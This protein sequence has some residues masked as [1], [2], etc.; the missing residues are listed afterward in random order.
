MIIN[1]Q[2]PDAIQQAVE[3]L[4]RGDVVVIPT[5]TVYGLAADASQPQAVEKIFHYKKRP[6]SNPLI[7]HIADV[8]QLSD[9]AIH[10]PLV[11]YQLAER[12]WPG[13]L[14][15]IVNKAPHVSDAITAGQATV[16]LRIPAHPVALQVLR[17]F[18]GG[19]AA[20][21]ANLF[22]EVSPTLATHVALAE[23]VLVLDG[24]P[25]QVGIESTIVDCSGARLAILRPG[26]LSALMISEVVGYDVSYQQA[27]EIKRPG[28]HWLHYSPKAEVVL[29][30]YAALT[31]LPAMPDTGFIVY[32]SKVAAPCVCLSVDPDAYAR[33]L[34]A[35]LHT[36]DKTC[37]RIVVE[38]PPSTPAWYAVHER[39]RKAAGM[40]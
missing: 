24:G 11:A 26:M 23:E 7:V 28:Q 39:L 8:A 34:Y 21:S 32:S 19:V 9:W 27:L 4:K 3:C 17:A 13:P 5:E 16:A 1:G 35:A 36:L 38:L 22:T 33:D 25:A 2:T 18:G 20:P 10:V 6:R 12:F 31:Q 29:C 37:R 15:L 14:T 30:D 40:M